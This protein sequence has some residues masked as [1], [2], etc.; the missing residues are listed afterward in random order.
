MKRFN[1]FKSAFNWIEDVIKKTTTPSI[2]AIAKQEYKDSREYTYIDTGEMFESGANSDFSNGFVTI[3]APQVRWLYYTTW[4]KAGAG[5]PKAVPQW[6]E[7]IKSENMDK[8][9]KIYTDKFNQ[10]KKG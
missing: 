7:K 1:D 2:E 3:K 10:I 6:H 9:I 8:Y 4:I 5:N